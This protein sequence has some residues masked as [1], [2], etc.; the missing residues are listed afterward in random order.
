MFRLKAVRGLRSRLEQTRTLRAGR[1]AH[2]LDDRQAVIVLHNCTAIRDPGCAILATEEDAEG[3]LRNSAQT[4]TH[5][6]VAPERNRA[7]ITRMF[8]TES[9]SGYGAGRSSIAARE[10]RSP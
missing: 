5:A 4:A 2:P 10:K 8:F 9:S 7:S 3:R 1:L 6:P